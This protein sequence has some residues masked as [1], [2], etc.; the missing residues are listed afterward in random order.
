MLD[1]LSSQQLVVR[2]AAA[3]LLADDDVLQVRTITPCKCT[4]SYVCATPQQ[5]VLHAIDVVVEGAV[6]VKTVTP[7]CNPL[8][9]HLTDTM[10]TNMTG[11]TLPR[12]TLFLLTVQ[13]FTSLRLSKVT[14]N[15][16]TVVSASE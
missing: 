9:L 2:T 13:S 10:S 4:A 15:I 16:A 6:R 3:Q 5:C 11:E 12:H 1:R 14:S 7:G 8:H